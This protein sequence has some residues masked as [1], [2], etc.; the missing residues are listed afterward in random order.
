MNTK[1]ASFSGYNNSV[2]SDASVYI[3]AAL[4][5]NITANATISSILYQSD[6]LFINSNGNGNVTTAVIS[7][8]VSGIVSGR[9]LQHPVHM[10]LNVPDGVNASQVYT[11][12]YYNFTSLIWETQGCTRNKSAETNVTIVCSCTHLTN[13]AVL[14]DFSG[15]GESLSALNA[16]VLNYISIVGCSISVVLM[17]L[18]VIIFMVFP[19]RLI[20]ADLSCS[21]TVITGIAYSAQVRGRASVRVPDCI[22]DPLPRRHGQDGRAP[23]VLHCCLAAPVL[24]ACRVHG[25]WHAYAVQCTNQIWLFYEIKCRFS[26]CSAR[27]CCSTK[28]LSSSLAVQKSDGAELL[29]F[30]TAFVTLCRRMH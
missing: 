28:H 3:P 7:V 9:P 12:C 21:L 16:A 11:C 6:A 17:G 5:T 30:A 29:L 24:S 13:F 2:G 20:L 10:T 18:V 14:L 8:T 26:G 23:S 25:M 22:P 19:V 27:L 1:V 4:K 15:S